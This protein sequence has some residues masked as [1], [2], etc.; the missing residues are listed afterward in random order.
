MA[1]TLRKRTHILNARHRRQHTLHPIWVRENTARRG[2]ELTPTT[3]A[4]TIHFETANHPVMASG[5]AAF[6]DKRIRLEKPQATSIL[7]ANMTAIAKHLDA[8][9]FGSTRRLILGLLFTH[10]KQEHYYREFVQAVGGGQGVVQRELRNLTDAGILIK[11]SDGRRTYYRAN[12][13]CPIYPELRQ[14]FYKLASH[15]E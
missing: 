5:R 7:A 12:P 9:L 14:L 15:P 4:G 13:D 8:A 1:D 6:L 2:Q 10:P 11:L 3:G